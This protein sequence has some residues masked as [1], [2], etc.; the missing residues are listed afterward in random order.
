MTDAASAFHGRLAAFLAA[1]AVTWGGLLLKDLNTGFDPPD[2]GGPFILL[3]FPA[4]HE[5]PI[6]LGAPGANRYREEG[7]ARFVLAAPL[8]DGVDAWSARLSAL[9]AHFRGKSFDGVTTYGAS[10]PAY[11]D[12]NDDGSYWVA[13]WV[14]PYRFDLFG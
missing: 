7:G 4:S 10:P 5:E 9:R 6:S 13:A 14:V 12:S 3:Q 2:D 11:D 1:D 8:G